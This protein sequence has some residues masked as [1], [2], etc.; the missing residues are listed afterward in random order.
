MM[1]TR[2]QLN[3]LIRESQK[4]STKKY[5]DDSALTGDQDELPDGLQ[6]GI[7]DKTVEDRE[8]ANESVITERGTGNPELRSDEQAL[9]KAVV[10]FADKYMMTMGMD[11]SDTADLQRTRRTIDDLI[12]AVMD[13]L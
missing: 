4:G 7:I 3:K 6:K 1:I 2:R 12:G 5:D 8:D 10:N 13:V 11:P 9:R